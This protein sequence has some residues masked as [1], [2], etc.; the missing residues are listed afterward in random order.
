MKEN[1]SI[2]DYFSNI[3]HGN[4]K[5]GCETIVHKIKSEI[6]SLKN[7]CLL[8]VDI[9][10]AFNSVKRKSFLDQM[11]KVFPKAYNWSKWLYEEKTPLQFSKFIIW[12]ETGV[13]QGDTLGPLL[14][15]TAIHPILEQIHREC[16]LDINAWYMD[17]G[18]LLGD[19]DKLLKAWEILSTEL[20]KIGLEL[21]NKCEWITSSDIKGPESVKITPKDELIILGVPL[22]SKE[23]CLSYLN[24]II[25]ENSKIAEKLLNLDD[26]QISLWL[27]RYGITFASILHL[28]R[29]IPSTKIETGLAKYDDYV[30]YYFEKI[31]GSGL[32]NN[33]KIQFRL[34][35][36][37][38]GFGFRSVVLH[39]E[40][41][42]KPSNGIFLDPEYSQTQN[43]LSELLD[44]KLQGLSR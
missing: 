1:Y 16:G 14:F 37:M 34:P 29:T 4:Q 12:S 18:N 39:S 8:K 6:E 11:A 31:I 7:W 40:A 32:N 26:S 24:K 38:G 19:P 10:N 23:F 35:I 36:R 20:P 44:N 25:K 27:F 2:Q 17:D 43:M 42:Y 15:C 28:L 5:R 22:G 30:A 21:G 13:Q 9:T 3:Q 33:A 41:A